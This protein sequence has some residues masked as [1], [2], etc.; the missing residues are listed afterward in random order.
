FRNKT[1]DIYFTRDNIYLRLMENQRVKDVRSLYSILT[2]MSETYSPI[3]DMKAISMF[4]GY[5]GELA[6][7][8]AVYND[9]AREKEYIANTPVKKRQGILQFFQF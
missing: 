2:S 7:V 9:V 5:S 1:V 6:S 8:D 3:Q 4:P